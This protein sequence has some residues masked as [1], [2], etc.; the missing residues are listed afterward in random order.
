MS[1][2]SDLA[3]PGRVW[4]NFIQKEN[5][6][7]NIFQSQSRSRS[8]AE[9]RRRRREGVPLYN[10][11]TT[12]RSAT[13]FKH[14]YFPFHHLCGRKHKRQ[15]ELFKFPPFSSSLHFPLIFLYTQQS[16]TLMGNGYN[17]KECTN[18]CVLYKQGSIAS[19]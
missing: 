8:R 13:I 17:T 2:K 14:N 12:N 3:D 18:E 4:V 5:L 11:L 15:K 1:V 6:Q 16:P 9:R 7:T 19:G 10:P